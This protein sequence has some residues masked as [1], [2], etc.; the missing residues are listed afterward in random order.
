MSEVETRRSDTERDFRPEVRAPVW[1]SC[2]ATAR[3]SYGDW[4]WV[5][6]RLAIGTEVGA[7]LQSAVAALRFRDGRIVVAGAGRPTRS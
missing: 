5:R 1:R 7:E 4:R 6:M 3:F 2:W